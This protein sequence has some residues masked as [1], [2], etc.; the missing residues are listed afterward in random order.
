M[1]LIIA[2]DIFGRTGALEEIAARLSS[3]TINATIID[4]Y[5]GRRIH[6]ES[7]TQAYA[8]YQENIGL[9]GYRDSI[10]EALSRTGHDLHL[11]GFS[12]GASS[13]WALSE[14]IS[15]GIKLRATC[16][17]GSQ[18]RHQVDV[19]PK[20]P[21]HLYFPRYEPHFDVST[22]ISILSSKKLVTCSVVPYLHGFMNRKSINFDLS[23]Y[24]HHMDILKKQLRI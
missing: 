11:V 6:F 5:A 2:A 21:M 3:D 19:E 10:L 20:I 1:D 15:S 4:P 17:Y 9:Q 18:I 13:I 22:L 23:G 16:F 8:Y 14:E 7:E 12:V 24:T